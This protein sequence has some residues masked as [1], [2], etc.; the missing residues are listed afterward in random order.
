MLKPFSWC[1]SFLKL[2]LVTAALLV[3]ESSLGVTSKSVFASSGFRNSIVAK[4]QNNYDEETI[5]SYASAVLE[6]EP[7]RKEVQRKIEA[8]LEGEARPEM[9]CNR[10]ESYQDLP[11]EARSLIINYCNRS[12][13]IVKEEGLS[14]SEFNQITQQIQNNPELKERVQEQMLELQ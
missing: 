1:P 7:I 13:E 8:E 4:A 2:T 14:I 9:A 6:I 3:A 11:E 5:N 10:S 12:E